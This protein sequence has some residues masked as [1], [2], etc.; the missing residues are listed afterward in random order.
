MNFL[1]LLNLKSQIPPPPPP[2]PHP[3][4]NITH[5]QTHRHTQTDIQAGTQAGTQAD[6]Y[7]HSHPHILTRSHHSSCL[8]TALNIIIKGN[9]L[10]FLMK[11]SYR[12]EILRWHLG[13][14]ISLIFLCCFW[15]LYKN[16]I[17]ETRWKDKEMRECWF[18]FNIIG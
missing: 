1:N 16:I 17:Y 9:V 14:R 7:R 15:Y 6:R 11:P 5:K 10:S 8:C 12:K 18:V 3:K 13:G 2:H 4:K